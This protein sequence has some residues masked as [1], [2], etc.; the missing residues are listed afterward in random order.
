[1]IKLETKTKNRLK[2]QSAVEF[3]AYVSVTIL[4]L[5]L[6]TSSI[7]GQQR[8]ANQIQG[9]NQ[10]VNT[11]TIIEENIHLAIVNGEGY[12][13]TFEIPQNINRQS[14]NVTFLPGDE[15]GYIR[16]DWKGL[17]D[18]SRL[19]STKY[20]PSGEFKIESSEGNKIE[21]SN[22]NTGVEIEQP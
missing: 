14:Y 22:K 12:S 1:M 2:G 21:I 13:R 18:Q 9:A 6:L 19:K 16:V 11:Y 7:S 15:N 8:K 10:A 5:A 4:A 20:N 3:I 17:Q